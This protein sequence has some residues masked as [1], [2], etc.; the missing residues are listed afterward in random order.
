[1]RIDPTLNLLISYWYWRRE[2]DMD[3]LFAQL[4]KWGVPYHIFL[5]SGAYTAMTQGAQIEI[6]DY[7]KWIYANKERIDVYAQLDVIRDPVATTQN[8]QIMEAEGL[9][10]L[11][12]Y[13]SGS[14]TKYYDA[15]V[16]KYAYLAVGGLVGKRRP[17]DAM[18]RFFVNLFRNVNTTRLH[19]FGI[20]RWPFLLRFPWDTMDSTTWMSTFRFGELMWFNRKKCRFDK[21]L[22][23]SRGDSVRLWQN[24]AIE[25]RRY[26]VDWKEMV[27]AKA[28]PQPP[29]A[30]LS[31]LSYKRAEAFLRSYHPPKPLDTTKVVPDGASD[32]GGQ[33]IY[34][35]VV[36]GN[37]SSHITDE[38][39][40]LY[41][42]YL[43]VMT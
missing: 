33:R 35:V 4:E 8:L 17:D 6:E 29:A 42:N 2:K 27:H 22:T 10:P 34:L 3:F 30:F 43:E 18:M 28:F 26:G 37:L 15:L 39:M 9:R 36:P 16:S 31:V 41:K 38:A 20:T 1:M 7:I 11:P 32:D 25:L 23:R 24:L 21:L 40:A 14:E 13:H 5:D 12:V 19:A